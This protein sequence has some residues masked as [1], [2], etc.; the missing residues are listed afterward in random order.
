[1]SLVNL[2]MLLKAVIN[3]LHLAV[4]VSLLDNYLKVYLEDL[5]VDLKAASL[6]RLLLLIALPYLASQG[7]SIYS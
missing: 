2:K 5:V 7:P 6:P 1:M 4:I 3:P